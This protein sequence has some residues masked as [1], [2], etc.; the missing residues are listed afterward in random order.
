VILA[1]DLNADANRNAPSYR[2]FREQG[3][4]RDAW[5]DVK[6]DD[7]GPTC[8]QADDYRNSRS[9]LE[10][11]IDVVLHR[12]EDLRASS[13]DRSGDDPRDKTPSGLWP[14]DHAAVIADLTPASRDRVAHR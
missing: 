5:T 2:L 6:K 4:F 3:R 9:S 10:R 12:G 8:C 14:S 11:R 7:P 13:A 1:G